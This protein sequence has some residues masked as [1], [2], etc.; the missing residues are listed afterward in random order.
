[1]VKDLGQVYAHKLGAVYCVLEIRQYDFGYHN[2][3][4]QEFDDQVTS[5]D[6][7]PAEIKA[8]IDTHPEAVAWALEFSDIDLSDA[9]RMD[10]EYYLV[11]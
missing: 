9:E 11:P 10:R 8:W 7:G 2:A 1:M 6:A 4:F 3:A 5:V